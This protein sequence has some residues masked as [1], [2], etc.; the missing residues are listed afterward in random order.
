[1]LGNGLIG[2]LKSGSYRVEILKIIRDNEPL[3]PKE[4]SEGISIHFSQ[5]SRTLLELEKRGLIE[6]TTPERKKGRIYRITKEGRNALQK[7]G[8]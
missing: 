5:G 3:T 6:C 7:I 1:M 8:E 4:I 2:F